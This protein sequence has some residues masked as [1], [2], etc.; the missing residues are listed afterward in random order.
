MAQRGGG[1]GMV[2]R[3]GCV[4]EVV[5]VPSGEHE[6]I[7]VSW[8]LGFLVFEFPCFVWFLGSLVSWFLGSLVS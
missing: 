6:K 2:E 5:G 3:E 8:F 7:V 1:G 4:G